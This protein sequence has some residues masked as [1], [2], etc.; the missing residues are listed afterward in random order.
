MRSGK[1]QEAFKKAYENYTVVRRMIISMGGSTDDAKDIF[2]DSLI[3]FYQ[4]VIKPDFTLN[5]SVK[6]L[7]Y[8]I[9]RNL[10]LKKIRDYN[11]KF[12]LAQADDKEYEY[13]ESFE[14]KDTDTQKMEVAMQ[15]VA[16]LGEPCKTLLT[17][18]YYEKLSMKEIAERL[19]YSG[20]YTA[21]A[22]KYKCI[23]RGKKML[24]EKLKLLNIAW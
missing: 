6:T 9:S 15:I 20:E 5:S 13:Q 3:V 12:V 14:D 2:Q 22:Q 8:S 18:F 7:L 16:M 4:M 21:K 23:E 24:T 11:S 1:R 17:L 19:G 10:W